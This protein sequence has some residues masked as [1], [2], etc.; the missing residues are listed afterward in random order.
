MKKIKSVKEAF[1]LENLDPNA[2]TIEGV[3]ERHKEALIA[4]AHLFVVVDAVNPTYQPDFTDGQW[5]KYVPWF[6]MG[7]PSGV[8][9]SY[10]D[11]DHWDT[12]SHVGARLV[13]ESRE[14]TDYIAETFPELYKAIM[15]Y[16]R[17]VK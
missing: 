4:M 16:E 15:V 14:A 13:S 2:I 17:K 5:N 9:F 8:G 1:E 10:D 12:F 3:P 11:Y 7:S 6:K